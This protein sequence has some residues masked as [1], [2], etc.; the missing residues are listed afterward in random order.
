[1]KNNSNLTQSPSKTEP[2]VS[3]SLKQM[4][5][6]MCKGK[7]GT[8]GDFSRNVLKNGTMCKKTVHKNLMILQTA[9][10]AEK[11]V[12]NKVNIYRVSLQYSKI[13]PDKICSVLAEVLSKNK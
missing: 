13:D 7:S 5:T 2:E 4:V 3:E 10:V 8:I 12:L 11:V 9:G 6:Y 1:M